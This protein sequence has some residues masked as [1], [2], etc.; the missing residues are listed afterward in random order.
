MTHKLTHYE[1]DYEYIAG[2]S[3]PADA[4][5]YVV[6]EADGELY[7]RLLAGKFCYVLNARQMGKSS[8]RVRTMKRLQS[9]GVRCA[10][11]EITGFGSTAIDAQVASEEW[12]LGVVRAIARAMGRSVRSLKEFNLTQ[13]WAERDGLSFVQRWSEFVEDVLLV[14]V[15]QPIVIFVDEIDSVLGLPFNADNF[16]AAIRECYN[17]RADQPEYKRLTFALL[18]VSTPQDLIQDVRRTP[19]NV[20]GAIELTGFTA[21]EAI[22]LSVGLPGGE[23]AL[24]EVLKWTGGQPFLTQKVCN[25][26]KESD[27]MIAVDEVVQRSIID[28]WEGK[29]EPVHLRDI[30]YRIVENES[31][32]TALL[33]LY[34][35]VLNEEG[36]ALESNDEQLALRLTGLVVK[37]DDRIQV[38]N[39][40]YEQVFSSDWV[41]DKLI[42]LRPYG[43][44]FH[45]WQESKDPK[46]LLSRDSLAIAK[47]WASDSTRKL[48]PEDYRFLQASDDLQRSFKFDNGKALNIQ[49]L[50]ALCE[51]YPEEA[52]KNLRN[53]YLEDWLAGTLGEPSLAAAAKSS[54]EDHR[55]DLDKA[56]EM[57]IRCLYSHLQQDGDP[58]IILEPSSFDIGQIPIGSR[59]VIRVKSRN[60]NRG[61]AWGKISYK[62][63]TDG[64][65]IT[66]E[67]FDS[68]QSDDIIV[69]INLSENMNLF[70][71]GKY[72]FRGFLKIEGIPAI[73]EFNFEYEIVPVPTKI[74]PCIVHLGVVK[75]WGKVEKRNISLDFFHDENLKIE[76]FATSSNPS[77]I[78]VS[79]LSPS[80]FGMP[81]LIEYQI[82]PDQKTSGLIEEEIL[83]SVN[84]VKTTI[85]IKFTTDIDYGYLFLKNFPICF[86]IGMISGFTRNLMG[87]NLSNS[88]YLFLAV[89]AV[90]GF[91]PLLTLFLNFIRA[92]SIKSWPTKDLTLDIFLSLFFGI[93]VCSILSL[94]GILYPIGRIVSIIPSFIDLISSIFALIDVNSLSLRWALFSYSLTFLGILGTPWLKK[95]LKW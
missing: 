33:G 46:W 64:I 50:I 49:E 41:A 4:E 79:K 28:N 55:I 57:F 68:R 7:E 76:V 48:T 20:G 74:T 78:K 14:Q 70:R 90:I 8:L 12:Y 5:S 34:Q 94:L 88:D 66:N 39:R 23:T 67:E 60:L 35:R 13:W 16:F 77:S 71:N 18:G 10:S 30:Q 37:R 29:D 72:I 22:G 62:R 59:R 92:D 21:E 51:S 54:V 27:G 9:A 47:A 61:L 91:F 43:D 89:I 11:I 31:I 69:N 80:A 86:V 53:G 26:V 93:L 87:Q 44:Q 84:N 65:K 38:T 85:P 56:L 15:T 73:H 24:V 36:V 1:I 58:F 63:E 95:K 82:Y 45:K 40:I 81:T 83:I 17:R 2:G 3:L 42:G 75:R 25:L 6:R 32:A 19:F 52:K